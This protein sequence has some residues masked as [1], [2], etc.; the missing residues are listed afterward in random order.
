[1]PVISLLLSS[2][3]FT[4]NCFFCET[5]TVPFILPLL[6]GMMLSL[7]RK[8]TEETMQEEGFFLVLVCSLSRSLQNRGLLQCPASAVDNGQQHLV[9]SSFLQFFPCPGSFVAECLRWDPSHEQLHQLPGWWISGK[10]QRTKLQEAPAAGHQSDFSTI[11]RAK[12]TPSPTRPE[13][14]LSW[15]Q[16]WL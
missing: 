1:M 15:V 16:C 10:F 7:V 8:D 5:E 2:S 14:P 6:P 13:G 3:K 4:L 9:T 12:A 11:Q